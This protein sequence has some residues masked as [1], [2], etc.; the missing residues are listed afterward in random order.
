MR[1]VFLILIG[2][3]V[4]CTGRRQHDTESESLQLIVRSIEKSGGLRSWEAL[5]T[6]AF[7]KRSILYNEDSTI[8]SSTFQYQEFVFHPWLQVKLVWMDVKDKKVV[9][10]G[11]NTVIYENDELVDGVFPIVN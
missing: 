9:Y 10:N 7:F 2:V 8:E 1:Y 4:S 5:D 3:L 11:K 6:L